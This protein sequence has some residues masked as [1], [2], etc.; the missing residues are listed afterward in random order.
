M[1]K[2]VYIGCV[3]GHIG[4]IRKITEILENRHLDAKMLR[5]IGH[6]VF[7]AVETFPLF[8]HKHFW[9][10]I[11]SSL[12]DALVARFLPPLRFPSASL[13]YLL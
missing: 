13:S 7:P 2:G 10:T 5:A 8:A 6:V 11:A 3:H 1:I 4:Q 9:V 12:Q